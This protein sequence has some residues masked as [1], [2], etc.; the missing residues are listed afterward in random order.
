MRLE[1]LKHL[2][3]VRRAVTLIAS[4]AEGRSLEDY[5]A[6]PMLRAAV[7]RELEI[8]GEALNRL[9]KSDPS[10]AQGIS[11]TPPHHRFPEH[12]YSRL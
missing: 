6:D 4:F 5:V 2:E 12:P 11:Y 3:D 9:S 7:E 1:S 8:I 10:V